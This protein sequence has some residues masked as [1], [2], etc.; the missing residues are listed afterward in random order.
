MPMNGF[1]LEYLGTIEAHRRWLWPRPVGADASEQYRSF[2]TNVNKTLS[3]MHADVLPAGAA[4][5]AAEMTPVDLS[6]GD[7]LTLSRGQTTLDINTTTGA[8]VSL[9]RDGQEYLAPGHSIGKLMCVKTVKSLKAV[10]VPYVYLIASTRT[11][12][13]T[14]FSL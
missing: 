3:L 10:L 9:V 13:F 4:A 14:R 2:A 6:R 5:A 11:Y 8:I 12:L 1:E 7:V